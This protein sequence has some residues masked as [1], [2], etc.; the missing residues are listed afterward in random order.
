M[1]ARRGDVTMLVT[2]IVG[3]AETGC[4]RLIILPGC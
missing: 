1:K 4:E 3:F 2:Y